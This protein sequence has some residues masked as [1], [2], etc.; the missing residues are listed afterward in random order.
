MQLQN[1]TDNNRLTCG[2]CAYSWLEQRNLPEGSVNC[3]R[4]ETNVVRKGLVQ[5]GRNK[6][7]RTAMDELNEVLEFTLG[8]DKHQWREYK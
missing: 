4:C 5:F 2:R 7:P 1:T 8:D 6:Q 3:P